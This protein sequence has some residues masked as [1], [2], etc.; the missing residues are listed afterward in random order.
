MEIEKVLEKLGVKYRL[1]KHKAVFTVGETDDA[2]G[3]HY[4]IKNLFLKDKS[5]Q[6]YLTIMSGHKRLDIKS[7]AEQ[8]GSGKLCFA[9]ADD[10]M[11]VLGVTPGSVSLFGIVNDK[12]HQ[13][14]VVVEKDLMA[15][16]EVS[17]HPNDN[18]AT[19]FFK[20]E[21]LHKIASEFNHDIKLVDM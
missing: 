17:F 14:Q 4:A 21:N 15:L 10:L 16:D 1:V 11:E 12:N 18:T 5:G 7:L 3:D 20:P 19:I 8:V 2:L 6:Y 9:K 13:V